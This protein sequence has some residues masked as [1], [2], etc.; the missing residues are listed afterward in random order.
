MDDVFSAHRR[1]EDAVLDPAKTAVIVV[2]MINEFCKPGGRMVLPGYEALMPAQKALVAAARSNGVPVI[3]VVDSHRKNMRRD[4]EW[5]KRTPHCVENTWAT[6]VIDD[7]EPQETDI[8][9]V[10]HRYSAFFQT[11]L[12]LVLKDMLIGQIVVFGV[13]TNICVRSTV[14]DGF[15]LGYDIVVPHDACAA[16]GAREHA[17]TLYDIATHFGTVSDAATI[18]AAIAGGVAIPNQVFEG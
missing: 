9:V 12:D 3:W 1:N 18:A 4:R 6:Q 11:D 17:S 13:V 14:H 7:L 10:K 5:V 2:D 8:T 16:T 15:F